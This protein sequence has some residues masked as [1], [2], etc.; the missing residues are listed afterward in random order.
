MVILILRQRHPIIKIVVALGVFVLFFDASLRIQKISFLCKLRLI[1]A[2]WPIYLLQKL[3]IN[4]LKRAIHLS[5]YMAVF[6]TAC[7][8]PFH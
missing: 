2:R 4:F 7:P 1:R 8:D 3:L 6:S 5:V